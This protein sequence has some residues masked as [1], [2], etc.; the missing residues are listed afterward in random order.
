M[1]TMQPPLPLLSQEQ[2]WR[3]QDDLAQLFHPKP[4]ACNEQIYTANSNYG[5][6]RCLKHYAGQPAGEPIHAI[7]P[8]G[9]STYL[10]PDDQKRAPQQELNP[11]IPCILAS[12]A[13]CVEAFRNCG[14]QQVVPIGLASLYALRCITS[15]LVPPQRH[16]SLFFRIHGT[17]ACRLIADD[18]TLIQQLLELPDHFHPIHIC[19]H[20]NDWHQGHYEPYIKAG[21]RIVGAGHLRDD[22]FIWRHWH[23]L[24]SHQR[25]ITSGGGTHVW[26]A[27]QLGLP[28]HLI[29]SSYRYDVDPAF[30]NSIN[31]DQKLLQ[32]MQ[33][34]F[35]DRTDQPTQT[36]RD[37]AERFL[38]TQF[39]RAPEQIAQLLQQARQI[40]WAAHEQAARRGI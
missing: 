38:G 16:G 27:I 32:L 39:L 33:Q 5:F 1:A 36:Q 37:L 10:S 21:F 29:Q 9:A 14:K 34:H 11:A 19:A 20:W 17:A 4:Q 18:A 7:V 8:H 24:N 6:S 31:A 40:H 13:D 23:L 15:N 28:V 26:H 12:S 30:Q 3:D 22:L 25:L 35:N 2:T